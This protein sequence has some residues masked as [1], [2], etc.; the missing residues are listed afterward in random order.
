ML[1]E[2]LREHWEIF[3]WC[4][5]DMPGVSREF[6]EHALNVNPDARP[7]KQTIRRLSKPRAQVVGMEINRLLE[8]KFIREIKESTWLA[9]TMLVPKRT[10]ISY[11]CAWTSLL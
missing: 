5:A 1:V 9:N 7:V 2:F 3:A 4:P 6:A 11:G 10:R 8:A